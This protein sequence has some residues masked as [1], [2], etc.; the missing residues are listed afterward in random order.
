MC[1]VRQQF[2]VPLGERLGS[3]L[4]RPSCLIDEASPADWAPITPHE[5]TP[6][7]LSFSLFL[8]LSDSPL[9]PEVIGKATMVEQ[10]F[11]GTRPSIRGMAMQRMFWASQRPPPASS[12]NVGVGV[13]QRFRWAGVQAL[14]FSGFVFPSRPPTIV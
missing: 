8:S 7:S 3:T 1:S 13:A 2:L 12:R 6:R 9:N 4:Q 10:P 5:G 14:R 11:T